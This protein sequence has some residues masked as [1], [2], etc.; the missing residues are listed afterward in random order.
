MV[1]GLDDRLEQRI[2]NVVDGTL[3]QTDASSQHRLPTASLR[4]FN[5]RRRRKVLDLAAF[6]KP[7]AGGDFLEVRVHDP[8]HTAFVP[9][10][11]L[12]LAQGQPPLEVEPEPV[13]K[14]HVLAYFAGRKRL[15]IRSGQDQ[16]F[17][18]VDFL[19]LVGDAIRPAAQMTVQ[20]ALQVRTRLR[21]DDAQ[22]D[23]AKVGGRPDPVLAARVKRDRGK[24]FVNR[25]RNRDRSPMVLPV[26]VRCILLSASRGS[27]FSGISPGG[28]SAAVVGG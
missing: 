25:A 20:L 19:Q 2:W 28:E 22:P 13:A 16:A 17:R 3:G 18:A 23:V 12:S 8:R 27:N 4:V 5:S 1:A 21:R 10:T 11:R 7:E 6:G 15:F 14:L 26:P 9:G 24:Q